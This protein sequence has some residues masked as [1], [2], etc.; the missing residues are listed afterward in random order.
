MNQPKMKQLVSNVL[1]R[2]M[3]FITRGSSN[4]QRLE[5]GEWEREFASRAI[6]F[7]YRTNSGGT[8]AEK[9]WAVFQHC[10]SNMSRMGQR[11]KINKGQCALS[12]H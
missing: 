5:G 9:K 1:R 4:N 11:A 10:M 2:R 8:E 3:Q 7:L 6:H 12:Y